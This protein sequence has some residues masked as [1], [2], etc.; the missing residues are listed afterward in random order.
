MKLTL[1]VRRYLV[2]VACMGFMLGTAAGAPEKNSGSKVKNKDLAQQYR[3]NSSAK[4]PPSVI[5]VEVG[6]HI[7][8]HISVTT[9]QHPDTAS[10]VYVLGGDDLNKQGAISVTQILSLEPNLKFR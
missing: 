9:G 5:W 2:G 3:S 10:N 4:K 7:P 6:S 1:L 8:Q